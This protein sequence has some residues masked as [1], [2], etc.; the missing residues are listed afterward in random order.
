MDIE[1]S[2]E[3]ELSLITQLFDHQK[4]IYP[5]VV[6]VK[7]ERR[8]QIPANTS[9]AANKDI[10]SQGIKDLIKKTQPDLVVYCAEA[11]MNVVTD[12]LDRIKKQFQTEH[13]EIVL[14][15]IEYK[16]GEKFGRAARIKRNG[17][18]ARLAKFQPMGDDLTQG[19]FMDFFPVVRN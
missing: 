3:Y 2:V 9:N 14:V 10:V 13:I 8:Y 11:W 19:R 16:T 18:S 1:K 4:E 7:E 6:L 12:K 15:H 17:Q 5:F